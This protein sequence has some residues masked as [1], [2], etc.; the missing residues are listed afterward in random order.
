MLSGVMNGSRF[1]SFSG[2][3]IAP[4]V[5]AYRGTYHG[6]QVGFVNGARLGRGIVQLGAVAST[7]ELAGVQLSSFVSLTMGQ[8]SGLQIASV[9]VAGSAKGLAQIGG[10]NAVAGELR[11]LQLGVYNY[12][13]AVRSAQIGLINTTG[14]TSGGVQIGLVNVSRE[15]GTSQVGLVNVLPDTRI[16]LL[17]GGGS[18]TKANLA[19]RFR[20]GRAYSQVGLGLG[21]RSFAGNFSGSIAYHRGLIFPLGAR[22]SVLGDV[23][24]AHIEDTPMK[25]IGEANRR[26]A[27]ASRLTLEYSFSRVVGA[28][29]T[30]GYAYSRRYQRPSLDRYRPIF[31]AGITLY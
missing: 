9:N 27:L 25:H 29:L 7:S 22:L 13:G 21:Y 17:V 15:A 18:L 12:A 31:E 4:L 2:V 28:Y 24:I 11:G 8:A 1:G 26:Y 16:Q 20:R 10:I 19:V 30:G 6:L 3:S 5:N 14:A 23:G